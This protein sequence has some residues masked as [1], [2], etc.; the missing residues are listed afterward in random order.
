RTQPGVCVR[1]WSALDHRARREQTEPEIRRVD[2]TG[3][4]LQLICLGEADADTFPWLDVPRYG[5]VMHAY[6]LLARLGALDEDA[7]P[8]DLARALAR[9]PMHPRLG[10]LLIEGQRLGQ[11]GRAALAAALLAER[12]PFVRSLDGPESSRPAAATGSDVLDRVEVLE[13]FE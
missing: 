6:W 9:L 8:T 5:A 2:L 1:L 12:P 3:A 11:P 10:R 4:V 13:A 7:R